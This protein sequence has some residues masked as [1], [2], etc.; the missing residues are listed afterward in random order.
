MNKPVKPHIQQWLQRLSAL[1]FLLLG[2]SNN[3][4]ADLSIEGYYQGSSIYVQ[5]PADEDGFGF[6]INRVTV[7]GDVI[8]VDIYASAFEIDLKE[9]GIRKGDE[10]LIVF[11]HDAG[12]RPKLLNP[13]ALRPASTFVLEEISCTPE[14][15]LTWSTTGESGKLNFLIEQKKWNK[16]VV[17]GEVTGIGTADLNQYTFNVL[18]H[19]GENEIRLAQID[20]TSQKRV[21]PPVKFTPANAT[22]P[23]L[24]VLT[25][26]KIIEFTANGKQVKTKYEIFDAYGNIVKKG[27]NSE[28]DYS[29]L[30]SGVYHINYDNKNDRIIVK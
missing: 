26:K 15:V 9:Y 20:N 27:Y 3:S 8:P 12:C 5:S 7:N 2:I 24:N 18:A 11:E 10:V 30:K 28:V 25:D 16:W 21:T 29:N 13:E 1:S 4:F 23:E 22:E 17:I 6:C 14:G 19:S